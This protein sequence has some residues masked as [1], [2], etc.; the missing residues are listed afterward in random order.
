[1][2]GARGPNEKLQQNGGVW[3]TFIFMWK[4]S[5]KSLNKSLIG[6]LYI[7]KYT[8]EIGIFTIPLL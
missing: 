4:K 7:R 8:Y 1:M 6:Y 3:R 2:R 5:D